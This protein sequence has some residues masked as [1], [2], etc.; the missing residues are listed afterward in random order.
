MPFKNPAL[1]DQES[2]VKGFTVSVR[3]PSTDAATAG[4]YGTF[5]TAPAKCVVDSIVERHATA[6]SDGGTV[7]LLIE[8]LP[9]GTAKDSGTDLNT[10]LNLKSTANTNVSA[11]LSTT[12]A[13][14]ELASGDSLGL[15]TS[16]TLTAV[17]DVAVTVGLHWIP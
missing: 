4:N 10:A 9:S 14:L 2:P 6:G 15:V 16:G 3:V 11:T 7:S 1:F 8:K 17:A 5:W 13:T 12:A